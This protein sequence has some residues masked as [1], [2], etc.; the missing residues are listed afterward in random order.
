M[1]PLIR[2]KKGDV[3]DSIIVLVTIFI[4]GLGLFIMAFIIPT[5]S[6]SLEDTVLNG[7]TEGANAI[8]SLER[9]GVTN[10]QRGFLFVQA[11][12]LIGVIVT[13]FLIRTNA[14][15]SFLYILFLIIAIV[16]S[17]YL[18]NAY[19]L[20]IANPAFAETATSQ[21]FIN[22]IMLNLTR[23]TLITGALSLIVTFSKGF[24]F[25]GGDARV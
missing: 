1:E 15:F 3:T 23:I 12:L 6:N 21:V 5:L 7:S 18:T 20:I 10:M 8:A 4:L 13:A 17:V 2:N 24:G 16:L 19:E 9:F 25:G 14:V 11:F 22:F